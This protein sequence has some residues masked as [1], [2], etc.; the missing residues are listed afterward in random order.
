MPRR[1]LLALTALVLALH[2]L[3]LHGIPLA[4]EGPTTPAGRV[5]ST[6]SVAAPPPP[7]TQPP[8]SPAGSRP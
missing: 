4:W 6:R 3:V 1:T 5:F 7:A 8:P 2:W